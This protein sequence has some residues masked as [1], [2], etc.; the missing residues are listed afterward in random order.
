MAFDFGEEN[1]IAIAEIAAGL[2]EYGGAATGAAASV[3]ARRMQ[4]FGTA[5]KRCQDALFEYRAAAK[6]D[7]V[8]A[9][10]AR[11]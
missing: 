4:G 10:A 9:A 7:T 5:V 6:T 1:T 11:Q 2:R 8:A 3:Y